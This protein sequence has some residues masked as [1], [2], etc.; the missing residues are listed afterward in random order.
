MPK[1]IYR[2]DVSDEEFRHEAEAVFLYQLKNQ[3]VPPNSWAHDMLKRGFTFV[4]KG[5]FHAALDMVHLIH[6]RD[7][8]GFCSIRLEDF[9]VSVSWNPWDLLE[10]MTPEASPCEYCGE[11]TDKSGLV[12]LHEIS[13]QIHHFWDPFNRYVK[14]G[15]GP[16]DYKSEQID[17]VCTG[18]FQELSEIAEKMNA[19]D[20]RISAKYERL[21]GNPD[22]YG[23]SF[24]LEGEIG[25]AFWGECFAA[26]KPIFAQIST[27]WKFREKA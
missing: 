6:E 16:E 9:P 12:S 23:E 2:I 17:T 11:V 21:H 3:N 25:N 26:W 18:C 19:A 7:Y 13:T 10:E 24:P 8:D 20:A 15:P 4:L 27:P 14:N 5:E 22:E 1:P